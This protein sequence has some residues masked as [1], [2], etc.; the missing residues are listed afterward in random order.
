MSKKKIKWNSERLLSL[1]AMSISFIT[2]LIFIYQTN[3][4][5][6]QNYLSILPYLD[7]S[8]TRN[9]GD[10]IFELNLKNHGVGPA[11]IES[12]I[13]EYRGKRYDLVDFENDLFIFL[14]T[15]VPVLDSIKNASTSTLDKGMAIPANSSYN[16][17]RIED[18][19]EGYE[20]IVGSLDNLL[21]NGLDYEIVYKSIQNERWLIHHNSQ[22]P[23]QLR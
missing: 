14:L 18:S 8:V 1:S 9:R 19:P 22:G 23:E 7:M 15:K 17:L 3:L 4:M 2:L 6:K 13:M 10:H 21:E 16:V 11:I 20:L 12:V 5:S